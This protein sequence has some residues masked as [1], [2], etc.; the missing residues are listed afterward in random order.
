MYISYTVDSGDSET[1]QCTLDGASIPCG[2][3]CGDCLFFSGAV[4]LNNLEAGSHDFQITPISTAGE[5]GQTTTFSFEVVQSEL[6][7]MRDGFGNIVADTGNTESGQFQFT[8]GLSSTNTANFEFRC[9][10]D[11]G[12]ET[13]CTSPV[14]NADL[15]LGNL[16][17][18]HHTFKVFAIH[19]FL[20]SEDDIALPSYFDWTISLAPPVIESPSPSTIKALS[21]I[22]SGNSGPDKEVELRD[23]L[24][25]I[26]TITA[27]SSGHWETT[28][29]SYASGQ[30]DTLADGVHTLVAKA[31]DTN[32]CSLDSDPVEITIHAA[33]V[34]DAP[35]QTVISPSFS[36]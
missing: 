36:V 8:F 35:T 31:C 15:G 19:P 18:G 3:F 27:D 5:T 1:A 11:Q 28:I 16:E 2:L 24:G 23:Q 21:F 22:V 12:S 32:G 25:V 20:G 6:S 10:I 13:A 14:T 17:S 34:I 26:D 33:P 30:P 9:S 7:E 29:R 4:T